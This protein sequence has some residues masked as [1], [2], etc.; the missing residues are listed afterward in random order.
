[1]K[2]I[3]DADTRLY[4]GNL[5]GQSLKES[6]RATAAL[7][8]DVTQKRGRIAKRKGETTCTSMDTVKL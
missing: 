7:H 1:M 8:V 2:M 4:T 5:V 3:E 6:V